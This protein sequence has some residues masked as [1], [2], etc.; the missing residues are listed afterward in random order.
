MN[1]EGS[2]DFET[3]SV[4]RAEWERILF[5]YFPRNKF[6]LDCGC[7]SAYYRHFFDNNYVG[8][9]IQQHFPKNG[10]YVRASSM[11]LPFRGGSF[12]AVLASALFEHI[13][14]PDKAL[15]EICRV[16]KQEGCIILGTPSRY[17]TKYET[18]KTFRGYDVE[19]LEHLVH[20]YKFLVKRRFKVG[21]VFAIVF[22]EIENIFK[23]NLRVVKHEL[24]SF[25]GEQYYDLFRH[26]HFGKAI[27]KLRQIILHLTIVMDTAIPFR[28]LYQGACIFAI[29]RD[30]D[31]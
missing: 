11:D 20:A 12:D 15:L 27:L 5:P 16:L 31:E 3:K 13:E 8:L 29:K 18:L 22:A 19:D 6:T 26:S 21:G 10:V 28:V 17:G 25:E 1:F 4:W 7:G 30:T 23:R 9:D 14:N 24:S 2:K